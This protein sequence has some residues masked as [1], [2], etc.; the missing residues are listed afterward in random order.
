MPLLPLPPLVSSDWLAQHLDRPELVILDGSWYLPSSGRDAREEYR[1]GHI[2]G[3]RFFDLDQASDQATRLPHML[4]GAGAFAAYVGGLGIS[5]DSVVVV[6]DGSGANMSSARVWWMFRVFGHPAVALLD[7]GLDKWRR[8]GRPLQRGEVSCT[9][10]EY[11]ARL[12][13][14]RVR[15]LAEVRAA[16]AEGTDQ[17]VDVRSAGRFEGT[18]PEPRPGLPSGHMPGAFNLPYTELVHPDGTA[19]SPD[20]LRAR[21]AA[22][23]IR[24]DRPIIVSCG[25]GTSA[26]TL[27]HALY[28]LGQHA[29]ALYDGS[30]TEWAG[31]GMPIA[32]GPDV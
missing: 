5:N 26:C 4:P 20:E 17:V 30:W 29:N 25:S 32:T 10:L 18:A 24:L 14:G 1:A 12:D 28:R 21:M 19:L 15:T 16:L 8:E 2:P 31:A 7:G 23:H 3:A 22:V 11:R 9:P 13:G 6:Y 27:L